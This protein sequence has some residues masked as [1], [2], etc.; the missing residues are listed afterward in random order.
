MALGPKTFPDQ[1]RRGIA[2]IPALGG[3]RQ[4]RAIMPSLHSQTQS[5]GWM[6][7][8]EILDIR[9]ALTACGGYP[10]LLRAFPAQCHCD[11]ARPSRA[12]F[13]MRKIKMQVRP[14]GGEDE[15]LVS[16]E[17]RRRYWIPVLVR[18]L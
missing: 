6:L 11:I 3:Q 12:R 2:A 4:N 10:G 8:S 17:A 1:R 15:Y 16:V 5:R 14:A 13:L 18:V 7:R 9:G